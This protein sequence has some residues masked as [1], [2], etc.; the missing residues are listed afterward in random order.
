MTTRPSR[1]HGKV[2]ASSEGVSRS[3]TYVVTPYM[4]PPR[5]VTFFGSF[6]SAKWQL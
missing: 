2:R 1:S 5:N 4:R 3:R 6:A